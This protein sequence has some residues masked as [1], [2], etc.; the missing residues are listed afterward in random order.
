MSSDPRQ[1]DGLSP[2]YRASAARARS[3]DP[4]TSKA[5]A[6]SVAD[7]TGTQKR[8]LAMF[9]AFGDMTDE[10]LGKHI[11]AAT[12]A[13]GVPKMSP[14]AVRSRRSDLS[15]PNMDRLEELKQASLARGAVNEAT[16]LAYARIELRREGFRSPLWDTGKREQISTGRMAT[17]WGIAR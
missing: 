1:I 4:E 3:A 13:T 6:A 2:E 5:A 14:S 9:R 17:V 15:K 12:R 11:E 8:V 10:E 7:L 16:A